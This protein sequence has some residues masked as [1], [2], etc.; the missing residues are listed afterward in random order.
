MLRIFQG[1]GPL[2][3]LRGL[4]PDHG[5]LERDV[6]TRWDELD[7]IPGR[8]L[9]RPFCA[10]SI[11]EGLLAPTRTTPS[12]PQ[13]HKRQH[14]DRR[15]SALLYRAPKIRA[16]LSQLATPSRQAVRGDIAPAGE[17]STRTGSHPARS[18]ARDAASRTVP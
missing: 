9:A 13:P 7:G 18:M 17:S 5:R 12:C 10:A 14:E 8:P 6:E 4:R 11:L 1:R 3:K 2:R 15:R 16:M